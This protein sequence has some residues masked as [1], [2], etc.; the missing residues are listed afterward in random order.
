MLVQCT[1]W[2]QMMSVHMPLCSLLLGSFSFNPY[3]SITTLCVNHSALTCTRGHASQGRHG[4]HS[5]E[6]GDGQRQQQEPQPK[7]RKSPE[8]SMAMG[9]CLHVQSFPFPFCPCLGGG[10]GQQGCHQPLSPQPL[11]DC[12]SPVPGPGT[13]VGCTTLTPGSV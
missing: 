3:F 7:H 12:H 4:L 6:Y 11:E 10:Q 9:L 2:P 5:S 13:L 8:S 1:Q